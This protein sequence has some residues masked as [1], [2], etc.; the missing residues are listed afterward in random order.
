MKCPPR[1][2]S[3]AGTAGGTWAAVWLAALLIR[4]I[5]FWQIHESDLAGALLGDAAVY[6]AWGQR[7]AAGAWLGDKVF[8]QA[9]LYPY[10]LGVIYALG[11]HSLVVVRLVQIVIGACSCVF[12]GKAAEHFISRRA[13]QAAGMLMALCPTLIFFDGLIQ[14]AVLDVFF[15][16]LVLMLAALAARKGQA[17]RWWAA[18]GA[19]FGAL[20]LTRENALVMLPLLLLWAWQHGRW[21]AVLLAGAGTLCVLLPV[22]LRNQVVGGEFHLTTSQMGP[23]FYIGNHE[24]ANGT[25]QPLRPR[26]GDAVY[27]EKDAADLAERELGR[28]LTPGEVSQFWMGKSLAFIRSQP[29]QWIRLMGRKWLLVWNAAE[30]GD[31]EEQSAYA[32]HSAL[33]R[34]LSAVLHFGV[35]CPLAV[36][37]AVW[38]WGRRREL[39]LVPAMGLMYAASVAAFYVFAR[40]RLPLFPMAILLAAGGIVE[41]RER[42]RRPVSPS[43]WKGLAALA[44]AAVLVN[45]PVLPNKIDGMITLQNLGG[46]FSK[47]QDYERA[48]A[49]YDQVL[50]RLPGSA[51]AHAGKGSAL[52]ELKRYDE[53]I[54]HFEAA[55]RLSPESPDTE[56][57]LGKALE[58]KGDAAAALPHYERAVQLRPESA[59][60]QYN[61]GN[62]LM[63]A[64]N[65]AAALAAYEKAVQLQPDFADPY[66]NLGSLLFETG[67]REEA[68]E[69]FRKYAALRPHAAGAHANLGVALAQS[70]H[71]AEAV[72]EY[73]AALAADAGQVPALNN[74]AWILATSSDAA[75]RD[76]ARAVALASK[77]SEL[78]QQS[79]PS[80]LRTLAAALAESGRFPEARQAASTAIRILETQGRGDLAEVI[81]NERDIYQSG[82]PFRAQP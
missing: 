63:K 28:R 60:I 18:L 73:E 47:R 59:E 34:W 23:N 31:T 43:T 6:D 69:H 70:G 4:L 39:W 33:L 9:P 15:L 26:R 67:R 21:R 81:R 65:K 52:I 17:V 77:A 74:L 19:G 54:T 36:M 41:I 25:Y 1:F 32:A 71:V 16:A 22:A 49:C 72:E 27:E 46:Y 37:G 75:L 48:I 82:R 20:V 56:S 62:V 2:L 7:I 42:L 58:G 57:N 64:G 40:Y 11:G 10:F 76:G 61:L 53:A 3:P 78:T 13:G 44:A 14:K 50:Q 68:L 35:L 30:L 79:N 38:L 45:W 66:N 29:W 80:V 8:Y 12:L 55:L 24:H 5:Y 51:E